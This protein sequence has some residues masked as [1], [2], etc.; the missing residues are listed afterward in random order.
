MEKKTTR[1]TFLG[2]MIGLILLGIGLAGVSMQSPS[3]VS[4][5]S[6]IPIQPLPSTGEPPVT[7][8]AIETLQAE[9]AQLK[10]EGREEKQRSNELERRLAALPTRPEPLE[11][12][13]EPQAPELTPEEELQR[14][15]AQSLAQVAL[16]EGTVQTEVTDPQWT[17]AAETSLRTA[18]LSDELP[19]LQLTDVTCRTTICRLTL[20]HDGSGA[21]DQS[22]RTLLRR[23]PWQGYGF[24]R[25]D[26]GESR[27]VTVY[28]AREGYPLPE[29]PE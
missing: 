1:R 24:V 10:K 19:N 4:Y 11:Q 14:A 15:E 25:I 27:E 3:P 26:Q 17:S 28:L 6:P 2:F 9:I 29:A 7:T 22:F 20:S 13:Q 12:I 8:K 16:L 5:Q 18:F 21:P 23:A